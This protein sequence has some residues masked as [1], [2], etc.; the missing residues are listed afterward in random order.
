LLKSVSKIL[1]VCLCTMLLAS[2][3]VPILAKPD[4][5][6]CENR[7]QKVFFT[8]LKGREEVPAV[9][10]RASGLAIFV[11]SNDYK[12]LYYLLHVNKIRETTAAHIHLGAKGA[13]GPVVAFLFGP[14]LISGKFSG[15][16]SKGAITADDLVGPLEGMTLRD[17]LEEIKDG[18]AYVNVHTTQNPMGEI[19]GQL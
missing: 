3:A 11:L 7:V 8:D 12:T 5:N 19:R 16:L 10:T 15:I 17:L 2:L 9:S 1:L 6:R 13:N 4:N 18:N 14:S